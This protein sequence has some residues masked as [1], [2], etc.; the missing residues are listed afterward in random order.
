MPRFHIVWG[1]GPGI[2]KPFEERVRKAMEQGLV[3]YRPRHRV[4]EL[5]T[6]NGAV[7]GA[8]GDV[9]IQSSA[10]RGEATSR[11]IVGDFEFYSQAVMVTS[12]GID[13]K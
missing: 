5:L 11:E 9:L 10:A 3:D 6:E 1:T 13:A 7:V 12:G 4:N 8:R 2:V